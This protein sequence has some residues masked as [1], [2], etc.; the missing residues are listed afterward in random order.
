MLLVSLFYFSALTDVVEAP[1]TSEPVRPAAANV[2]TANPAPVRVEFGPSQSDR[3]TADILSKDLSDF[4]AQ[5]V[6][7]WDSELQSFFEPELGVPVPLRHP[8]LHVTV[9]PSAALGFGERAFF[10]QYRAGGENG[11]V[12]KTRMWGLSVSQSQKALLLVRFDPKDTVLSPTAI[13]GVKLE[14]FVRVMGCD[15]TFKRRAGA[16]FGETSAG[17]CRLTAADGRTIN[18][19]ERHDLSP[20]LWE[21]SDIGVDAQGN[22]VFGNI[23]T[24]PTKLRRAHQFVCWAGLNQDEAPI[25]VDNIRLHDQGGSANVVLGTQTIRL[26]LRNVEWPIGNN[27]PSLTLYLSQN[28]DDIAQIFAWTDPNSNRI[29][30]SYQSFQASCTRTNS[31]E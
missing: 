2:T 26:R 7:T 16:F 13:D 12:V 8:R 21:V 17:A 22:R 9:R 19:S 23:D 20:D 14:D 15:L 28:N 18:V 1:T 24:N 10:V 27:R 6:G 11:E 5:I 29:A 30:L 25:V 31:N 4:S 3:L